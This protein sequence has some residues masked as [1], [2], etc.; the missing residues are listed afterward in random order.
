MGAVPDPEPCNPTFNSLQQDE[1]DS[2]WRSAPQC[3][4]RGCRRPLEAVQVWPQATL[5][6]AQTHWGYP[7]LSS[8][9]PDEGCPCHRKVVSNFYSSPV[10]V[11]SIS[12]S[13]Q[14]P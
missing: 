7:V 4:L 10:N 2:T 3:D 11:S 5:D 9:L 14:E 13:S 12:R 8:S 1:P 6:P